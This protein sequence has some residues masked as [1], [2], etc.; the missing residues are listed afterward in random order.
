MNYETKPSLSQEMSTLFDMTLK[1]FLLLQ[2]VLGAAFQEVKKNAVLL[3]NFKQK[4]ISVSGKVPIQ[5]LQKL[6]LSNRLY[7]EQVDHHRLPVI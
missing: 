6:P 5:T 2:Q 7:I 3:T 4:L 1:L